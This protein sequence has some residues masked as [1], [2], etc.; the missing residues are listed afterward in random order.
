VSEEHVIALKATD[1]GTG[2]SQTC[3]LPAGTYV[4]TT[5]DPAYVAHEQHFANGTVQVTIKETRP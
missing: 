2:E 4:V 1:L 3:K 5:T